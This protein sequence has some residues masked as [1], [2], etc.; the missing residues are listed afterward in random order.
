[1]NDAE[2]ARDMGLNPVTSKAYRGI[3]HATFLS[4]D[5]KPWY[6]NIGKRLVKS[7]KGYLIDTLLMC[8]LLDLRLE[9]LQNRRP[10]LYGHVVENFVATELTKL[11]S[12]SDTRATLLHFRTSDGTEVDFVL[13]RPD[14]KLAA[15]EVKTSDRVNANDFKG[16]YMLKEIAKDDFICGIILYNGRDIVPFGNKLFAVPISCL[17]S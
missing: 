11:L 14:G 4:F 5:V 2:I 1:M 16:I 17:W 12:F 8:H 3:L 9:E 15:I 10:E 13:E 7:S 6:R